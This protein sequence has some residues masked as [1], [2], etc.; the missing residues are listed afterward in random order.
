MPKAHGLRRPF[1]QLLMLAP[2]PPSSLTPN[3][4]PLLRERLSSKVL[5]KE[6]NING[7]KRTTGARIA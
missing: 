4:D 2:T 1:D 3:S 7:N 6:R 5:P